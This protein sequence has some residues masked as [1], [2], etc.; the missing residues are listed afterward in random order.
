MKP[1]RNNQ[2]LLVN[3]SKVIWLQIIYPSISVSNWF[4]VWFAY[5]CKTEFVLFA[6]TES[7]SS[8]N[9]TQGDFSFAAS[10]VE[11]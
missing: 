3:R 11:K 4:I 7:I 8:I 9:T 2:F 5:G 6:P 10:K 1:R